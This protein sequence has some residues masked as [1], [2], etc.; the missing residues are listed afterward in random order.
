[1]GRSRAASAA[2]VPAGSRGSVL[3]GLTASVWG[4]APQAQAS[5]GV[6]KGLLGS[7]D[8]GGCGAARRWASGDLGRTAGTGEAS[9]QAGLSSSAA[10]STV[11]SHL[12]RSHSL[13]WHSLRTASFLLEVAECSSAQLSFYINLFQHALGFPEISSVLACQ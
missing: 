11:V 13:L 10:A 2:Q 5:P 9:K 12:H 3:A 1:M 8:A 7:C 6:W 4:A